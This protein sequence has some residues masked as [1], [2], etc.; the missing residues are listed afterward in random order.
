MSFRLTC[1]NFAL[2]RFLREDDDKNLSW[3]DKVAQKYYSSLYRE[4]AVCDLKHY[5]SGNVRARFL[6][7]PKQGIID[8]PLV[9]CPTVVFK[10]A[11]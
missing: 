2:C 7:T 1:V 10:M 9:Y 4:F 8:Y 11:H 3:D 6:V 5:K